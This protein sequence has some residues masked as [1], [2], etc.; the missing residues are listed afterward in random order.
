ME[1]GHVTT[2]F[3]R[4]PMTLGMLASQ[5]R[6]STIEADKSIDKWKLF[7]AVCE[8]RE[9]LGVSDRALSILNALLS[10]YPKNELAA[11]GGLIVFPSN[12]QL[13]VRTHGMSETT[14]RRYLA[15][16]VDA[17]LVVRRDS[18]NGKRYARRGRAGDIEQAYGFDLSPLLV[19]ADEIQRIAAEIEAERSALR[20]AKE[21]L[22]L[23]RRDVAK[24]IETAMGE[25]APGDW[26][27]VQELY[28]SISMRLPRRASIGDVTPLLEEMEM[29]REELVNRLERLA[30]LRNMAG[31]DHQIGGHIQ[32]SNPD[33][34]SDLEPG[35]ETK[36][37]E[38]PQAKP[39]PAVEPPKS[40]P[41]AMVL[42]ACPEI[43]M[44][45]PGGGISSWRELMAAA[46]VVR[47]T[48]GVSPSAYERACTIMGPENAATV[49]ACI[50]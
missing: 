19:R 48:L 29:L 25:G 24:L 32:N 4:R 37:G 10:F 14:L 41:L 49:I 50:L 28:R 26:M 46:V 2:P 35:F 23:C 30:D 45:G 43:A 5:R 6:A 44:Y 21:R 22:S 7:R 36:Q 39:R 1:S 13:A 34:N 12:E 33:S 38:N 8:A 16:L 17:G 27:M 20:V 42:Q 11:D 40:F 31:N 47:S 3:G 9:G 18:P 15:S